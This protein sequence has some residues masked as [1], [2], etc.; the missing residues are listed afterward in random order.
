MR[1]S[2]YYFNGS[3][4]QQPRTKS[5]QGSVLSAF[6]ECRDEPQS[7]VSRVSGMASSHQPLTKMNAPK[8]KSEQVLSF[9]S[10][11]HKEMP[12]TLEEDKVPNED[13]HNEYEKL[14]AK[15]EDHEDQES[16]PVPPPPD[17]IGSHSYIISSSYGS[18]CEP[19]D[20]SDSNSF[21]KS[22]TC[23][24]PE[25][26]EAIGTP[27]FFS[28]FVKD[29]Q[30]V[31]EEI[32]QKQRNPADEQCSPTEEQ[33]NPTDEIRKKV[34]FMMATSFDYLV[35]Q[36][37][38]E[39]DDIDKKGTTD[40]EQLRR[41]R[42]LLLEYKK[43]EEMN[44]FET[45]HELPVLF[46]PRHSYS[47]R[48]SRRYSRRS[49]LSLHTQSKGPVSLKE[50]YR[51]SDN[52][53]NAEPEPVAPAREDVVEVIDKV[54]KSTPIPPMSVPL[55]VRSTVLRGLSHIDRK[56][57]SS[58]RRLFQRVRQ[59]FEE[60]REFTVFAVGLLVQV[61]FQVLVFILER[62]INVNTQAT[63]LLSETERQKLLEEIARQE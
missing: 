3:N 29:H 22:L 8:H 18:D 4:D 49:S 10:H 52:I 11:L 9:I 38:T 32:L 12:T 14:P 21:L 5:E 46:R 19:R 26:K 31:V 24:N 40:D 53:S 62:V 54:E 41:I 57:G 6:T 59:V 37:R 42:N 58:T 61:L 17:S 39:Y 1:G 20:S 16:P 15:N 45:G 50:D 28:R 25:F 34:F 30:P 27:E 35:W 51:G 7:P 47:V 33:R 13:P 63:I 48:Y 44:L 23:L 55:S 2:A 43:F 56:I 60:I 36:L